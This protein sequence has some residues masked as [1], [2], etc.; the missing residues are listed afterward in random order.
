MTVG[1]VGGDEL[2]VDLSGRYH[3]EVCVWR[4]LVDGGR[5]GGLEGVGL[6]VGTPAGKGVAPIQV[7]GLSKGR[8]AAQGWGL[9]AAQTSG[10]RAGGQRRHPLSALHPALGICPGRL[11][12]HE[13]PST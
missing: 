10:L 8:V 3:T 12:S 6:G 7:K 2:R 9:Q 5:R 11:R 1:V 13:G 4:D